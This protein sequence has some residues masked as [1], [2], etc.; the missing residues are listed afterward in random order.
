MK[1]IFCHNLI[2]KLKQ[3]RLFST[4]TALCIYFDYKYSIGYLEMKTCGCPGLQVGE[5]LC[6]AC[7]IIMAALPDRL[8]FGFQMIEPVYFIDDMRGIQP[9][10]IIECEVRADQSMLL[11]R[12][13]TPGWKHHNYDVLLPQEEVY[14]SIDACYIAY[15]NRSRYRT[16]RMIGD[17]DPSRADVRKRGILAANSNDKSRDAVEIVSSVASVSPRANANSCVDNIPTYVSCVPLKFSTSTE[18]FQSALAPSGSEVL[19]SHLQFTNKYVS[20]SLEVDSSTRTG[21]KGESAKNC[22]CPELQPGDILCDS[23]VDMCSKLPTRMHDGFYRID[24][25]YFMHNHRGILPAII[26]TYHLGD[27]LMLTLRI[28]TSDMNYP[29]YDV[30][31]P[32]DEVHESFYACKIANGSRPRVRP[33]KLV[34]EDSD[35]VLVRKAIG[36]T[37]KESSSMKQP[38]KLRAR[39][40]FGSGSS[41]DSLSF[42]NEMTRKKHAYEK[43]SSSPLTSS[44]IAPIHALLHDRNSSRRQE[45]DLDSQSEISSLI[46]SNYH[47][48]PGIEECAGFPNSTQVLR[49]YSH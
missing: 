19:R 18:A 27:P 5:V 37:K 49:L 25:V 7:K 33:Q 35:A 3:H 6:C 23:C 34:E 1:L 15:K 41:S 39:K 13:E 32:V 2:L 12:N 10:M 8:Q 17:D 28:S 36:A 9:G 4:S 21:T 46:E 16:K 38:K 22:G 48:S 47:D 42:A 14:E 11:V 44:H 40:S 20:S 43:S 31:L 24:P 26:I 45:I 29:C 30:K